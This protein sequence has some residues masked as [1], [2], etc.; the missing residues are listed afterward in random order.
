MRLSDT[1]GGFVD[2]D[3]A[4]LAKTRDTA[5]I[6]SAIISAFSAVN[7]GVEADAEGADDGDDNDDDDDG[8]G[9]GYDYGYDHVHDEHGNYGHGARFLD[10]DAAQSLSYPSHR[11]R[12]QSQQHP[13]RSQSPSSDLGPP[14]RS[15]QDITPHLEAEGSHVNALATSLSPSDLTFPEAHDR[16]SAYTRYL[17]DCTPATPPALRYSIVPST[18][19]GMDY[20]AYRAPTVEAGHDDITRPDAP[21][22]APVIRMGK[23]R[24]SMS[25]PTRIPT[26]SATPTST[27][28]SNAGMSASAGAT[29]RRSMLANRQQPTGGEGHS[30][31]QR[32]SRT[33]LASS[34]S[35]RSFRSFRLSKKNSTTQL[36]THVQ[37]HAQMQP[38]AQSPAPTH[39]P[40]LTPHQPQSQPSPRSQSQYHFETQVQD[41]PH[42]PDPQLLSPRDGRLE[43]ASTSSMQTERGTG[44]SVS[45]M[46]EDDTALLSKQRFDQ[47]P[48][49]ARD[50]YY[51]QTAVKY[52][53]HEADK[54]LGLARASA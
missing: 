3:E 7:V 4:V 40:R 29:T 38:P 32:P 54:G 31:S 15:L 17:A 34:L 42:L 23:S 51:P 6:I 19:F 53:P 2:E 35:T 43:T 25:L 14:S 10:S 39:I 30:L 41:E 33:S 47:D 46:S 5:E 50:Q 9:Y 21:A 11:V 16:T 27:P 18:G 49:T 28:A 26:S 52:D 12:D 44:T 1:R 8:H 48:R 20:G 45:S 13:Q 22:I 36:Q 24:S 37:L